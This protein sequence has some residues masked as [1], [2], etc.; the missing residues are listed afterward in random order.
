MHSCQ[1]ERA[2]ILTNV[3]VGQAF[4]PDVLRHAGNGPIEKADRRRAG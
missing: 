1:C 2:F 4:L 3:N